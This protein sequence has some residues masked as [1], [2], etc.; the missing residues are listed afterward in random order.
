MSL[1]PPPITCLYL[2]RHVK[3]TVASLG[4]CVAQEIAGLLGGELS[5]EELPATA[6][7]WP[8]VAPVDFDVSL[9]CGL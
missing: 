6:F 4:L 2:Q 7:V 5:V 3:Q 9:A 1:S 8:S